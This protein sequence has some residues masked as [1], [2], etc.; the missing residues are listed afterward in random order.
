MLRLKKLELELKYLKEKVE[1]LTQE[2]DNQDIGIVFNVEEKEAVYYDATDRWLSPNGWYSFKQT[3]IN[4][5][6]NG[7]IKIFNKWFDVNQVLFYDSIYEN[8]KKKIIKQ[9]EKRR[10]QCLTTSTSSTM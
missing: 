2:I 1:K 7:K 6:V 4:D 10:K 3:D 9:I 5:R 8:A